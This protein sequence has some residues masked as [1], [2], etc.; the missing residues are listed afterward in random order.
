MRLEDEPFN[1][2]V[3][4]QVP[5]DEVFDYLA[6]CE[7]REQVVSVALG[8]LQG[9]QPS[10]IVSTV[11]GVI[12]KLEREAGPT[13]AAVAVGESCRVYLEDHQIR[14]ATLMSMGPEIRLL[15]IH[16]DDIHLMF[17]DVLT[18]FAIPEHED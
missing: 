4:R 14:G 12:G 16:L 7:G 3:E 8:A 11:V 6:Q 15:V 10:A 18:T 1:F 2:R 17:Q 9:G 13:K 5:S